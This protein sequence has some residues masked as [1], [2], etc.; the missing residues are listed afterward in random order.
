[1]RWHEMAIDQAELEHKVDNFKKDASKVEGLFEE[2]L[3]LERKSKSFGN[4][5]WPLP[6]VYEKIKKKWKKTS[7]E[8]ILKVLA[9]NE[10]IYN[11]IATTRMKLDRNTEATSESDKKAEIS[12]RQS[13][14]N[15]ELILNEVESRF[16]KFD[17][18]LQSMANPAIPEEEEENTRAKSSKR[19]FR[20]C[21]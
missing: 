16:A 14:N 9:F 10:E 7:L 4:G 19:F 21:F 20:L 2:L 12:L 8:E 6:W 15:C 1:M 5:V 11:S 13:I 18:V 3:V 17:G